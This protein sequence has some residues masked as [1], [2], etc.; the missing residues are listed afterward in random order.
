MNYLWKAISLLR[1]S[2]INSI[3][4]SYS[5]RT[6]CLIKINTYREFRK[7][8][9]PREV[10]FLAAGGFWCTGDFPL[11]ERERWWSLSIPPSPAV[12]CL[13]PRSSSKGL[14]NLREQ[15]MN[16]KARQNRQKECFLFSHHVLIL[17]RT[18]TYAQWQIK[19]MD[20]DHNV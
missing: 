2:Q 7:C 19:T 13:P 9:L 18:W 14:G 1:V 12:P 11:A 20:S 8:L 16:C 15:Q 4:E 10:L 5:Q 3:L 17:N 6:G